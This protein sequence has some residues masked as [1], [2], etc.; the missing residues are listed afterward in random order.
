MPK[1]KRVTKGIGYVAHGH[2]TD[3]LVFMG[4]QPG[5]IDL[6]QLM[7]DVG[8]D[9]LNEYVS[10]AYFSMYASE[11]SGM[12][13]E[14]IGGAYFDETLSQY[15]EHAKR[16]F[17]PLYRIKVTIEAEPIPDEKS[18]GLWRAWHKRMKSGKAFKTP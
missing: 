5:T 1:Q 17:P 4:K 13:K 6:S 11:F 3:M 18:D 9:G 14:D 8:V 15:R 7:F 16:Q 2:E 12:K 10:A